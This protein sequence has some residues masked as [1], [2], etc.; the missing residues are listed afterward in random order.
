[1]C[2]ARSPISS[3]HN[4]HSCRCS[5]SFRRRGSFCHSGGIA[6]MIATSR[7][8]RY[9][10]RRPSKRQWRAI[11]IR[12]ESPRARS[13]GSRGSS[14]PTTSGN[15]RGSCATHSPAP[16]PPADP[17]A[18]VCPT[19]LPFSGGREEERSDRPVRPTA[20]AG[21][22]RVSRWPPNA[23]SIEGP[24]RRAIASADIT[25]SE[26]ATTTLSNSARSGQDPDATSLRPLRCGR[27]QVDFRASSLPRVARIVSGPADER[28]RLSR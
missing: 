18:L 17:F 3:A 16:R 21:W 14:R 15:G 8:H 24:R 20:T 7:Q 4:S 26:P 22:P 9:R 25:S 11:R 13:P 10:R 27:S 5:P 12:R 28:T 19:I 23:R 2:H 1:M 6:T